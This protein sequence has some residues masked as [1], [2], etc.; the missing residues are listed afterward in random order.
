MC[1]QTILSVSYLPWCVTKKSCK[2]HKAP[3]RLATDH[4]YHSIEDIIGLIHSINTSTPIGVRNQVLVALIYATGMRC[5]ELAYLKL[6]DV[7]VSNKTIKVFGKN[8]TERLIPLNT[9]AAEW[10]EYYLQHRSQI[11]ARSTIKN[12]N[13]YVFVTNQQNHAPLSRT[14]IWKI[15]KKAAQQAGLDPRFSTH[16]LRHAFATHLLRNGANLRV[17]QQLLGHAMICTTQ[18]Y[19]HLDNNHLKEFIRNTTLALDH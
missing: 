17:V 14:T 12:N 2:K 9:L 3:K 8:N 13:P 11:I 6:I 10:F 1:Y 18:L 16:S 15:I 5:S 7:D 19:T 4:P